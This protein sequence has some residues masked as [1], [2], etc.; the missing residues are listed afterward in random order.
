M[1]KE[2]LK[3]AIW[4]IDNK[5]KEVTDPE[6]SSQLLADKRQLEFDL[7]TINE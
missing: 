3:T 1:G 7:K 6:F 5:L 4:T 2:E